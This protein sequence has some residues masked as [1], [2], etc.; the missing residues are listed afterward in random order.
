MIGLSRYNYFFAQSITW[1]KMLNMLQNSKWKNLTKV[2][3]STLTIM[4]WNLWKGHRLKFSFRKFITWVKYRI[5]LCS[6]W[7]C[8]DRV[9]RICFVWWAKSFPPKLSF[10]FHWECCARLILSMNTTSFT[11]T[12]NRTI[13][14]WAAREKIPTNVT[15]LTL[16]WP[17]NFPCGMPTPGTIQ[18]QLAKQVWQALWGNFCF[19]NF[20]L[21]PLAKISWSFNLI[22]L[23]LT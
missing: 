1:N 10:W 15:W 12:S 5:A 14:Q 17:K 20:I 22:I 19:L 16:V 3:Q 8:W 23:K 18:N 21:M 11:G 6:S 4:L 7:T 13:L 2:K 9:L